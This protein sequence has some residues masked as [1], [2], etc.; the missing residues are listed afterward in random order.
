MFSW[1]RFSHLVQWSGGA[2]AVPMSADFAVQGLCTDS[3][4]LKAGQ[5]FVALKGETFDGHT[6]AAQAASLG[7]SA[8]I[9]SSPVQS[10]LPTLIV[11]DTLQALARIASHLRRHFKGPVFGVTGSAGK[12]SSKDAI[13]LLMGP[14]TVRS[15]ASFNNL[16]GVSRTIFLV[17]DSTKHLILEIGMNAFGEIEEICR[18]FKPNAGLITN[19]GDAHIGKL[20]GKDGIYRAKK[21]LFDFLS[22]S[23]ECQGVALNIDDALVEKAFR[24]SF[25][26]GGRHITYS[27]TGKKAD[28]SVSE[29]TV[30]P[31]TGFLSFLLT[32]EGTATRQRLPVFGLHHAQ[33]AA[34]AL[35]A[36]LVM[37]VPAASLVARLAGFRPASHRGEIHVLNSGVTLID[38]S[39]NSN[40]SALTSSLSSLSQIASERRRLLILG[41]MRELG[42][43]SKDLHREVG[44]TLASLLKGH[45][46]CVVG[47]G[48]D[49]QEL[50][51]PVQQ[52]LGADSTVSFPTVEALIPKLPTLVRPG[53][54]VFVKGSRG[55]RLDKAVTHLL[56]P[57]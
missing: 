21:E 48:T 27:S 23:G 5:V 35:A 3:R 52:A 9:V 38:E 26:N 24:E 56:N 32:L 50:L 53:E 10:S 16:Q 25:R 18:N 7:A 11:D 13:A 6:F 31:E 12:S 19:I 30:D 28:V 37:G 43:F 44:E 20:G 4:N 47:V 1:V 49:I 42:E 2:L 33:N 41:D 34:A 22:A 36:G 29:A 14:D 51:K 45:R 8:L 55:V 54:L 39:Y 40:P 15:P 46:A 57:V 17:G